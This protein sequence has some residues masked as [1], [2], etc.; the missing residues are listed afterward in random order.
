M[1]CPEG[2]KDDQVS[3]CWKPVDYGRGAGYP[4]SLEILLSV[5]MTHAADVRMQT[6][7]AVK[8]MGKLFIRFVIR[9]TPTPAAVYVL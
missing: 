5:W 1:R 9:V 8:N 2:F 7:K 4:W 3:T 6:H